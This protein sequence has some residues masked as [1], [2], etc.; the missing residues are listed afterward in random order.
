[1]FMLL[2]AVA[3]HTDGF[4][5]FLFESRFNHFQSNVNVKMNRNSHIILD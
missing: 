3:I 5:Q 4:N 1:M 2:E